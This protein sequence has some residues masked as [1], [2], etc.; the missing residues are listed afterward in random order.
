M[1]RFRAL[2]IKHNYLP[3]TPENFQKTVEK[4]LTEMSEEV[5]A[6]IQSTTNEIA[7]TIAVELKSNWLRSNSRHKHIADYFDIEEGVEQKLPVTLIGNRKKGSQIIR[8]H[9]LGYR[10]DKR[11]IKTFTGEDLRVQR[12]KYS[13]EEKIAL[14]AKFKPANPIVRNTFDKYMPDLLI[15][16]VN[17]IIDANSK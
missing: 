11:N 17:S 5:T 15:E 4:A 2:N 13:K 8:Y 12:K 3:A 14:G 7:E 9:E 16:R 1:S 10:V 6:Q